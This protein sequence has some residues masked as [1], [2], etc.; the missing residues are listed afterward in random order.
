MNTNQIRLTANDV[1][2]Y[3]PH[4][5]P[6]RLVDTVEILS[7]THFKGHK[8][9]GWNEPLF[10]GHFPGNPIMPGV[11]Q[12][13]AV[14]QL[15]CVG[16]G[17][18]RTRS[19]QV[20][21]AKVDHAKFH[22]PVLP[23]CLLEVE[24]KIIGHMK[25]IYALEGSIAVDGIT[26]CETALKAAV[27]D[28]EQTLCII[29]P[30][31]LSRGNAQEIFEILRANGIKVACARH[32]DRRAPLKKQTRITHAQ[33]EL[34]YAEHREKGFFGDLCRIMSSG[35]VIIAVLEG[36]NVV[37]RYREIMGATDPTKAA[38]GTLRKLFGV[39]LDDNAVHGSDSNESAAREIKIFFPG[40]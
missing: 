30:G 6:F 4:A 7:E 20:R 17:Y 33:A 35:D 19:W 31:A 37:A 32:G 39:N 26:V 12:I 23:G 29:K 25:N 36:E 8:Y 18:F 38:E 10:Q 2:W 14:A 15:A 22:A 34:F 27:L 3:M 1:K 28:A 21:L 13:E 40:D 11:L 24:A 16:L 5:Y 9:L